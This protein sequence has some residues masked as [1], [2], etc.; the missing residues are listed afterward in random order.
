MHKSRQFSMQ[1]YTLIIPF[2]DKTDE[3]ESPQEA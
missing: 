3:R 1:L 2:N